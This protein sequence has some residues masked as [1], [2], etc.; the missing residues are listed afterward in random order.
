MPTKHTHQVLL[1][2]LRKQET[3]KSMVTR[4]SREMQIEVSL[5]TSG[6]PGKHRRGE[7]LDFH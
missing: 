6:A 1:R 4:L 5:D 7:E 2:S 3:A